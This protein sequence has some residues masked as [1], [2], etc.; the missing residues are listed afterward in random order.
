MKTALQHARDRMRITT[1]VDH[2]RILAAHCA[3]LDLPAPV[4]E[5]PFWKGRQFK[6]DLAWPARRFACEVEG[7]TYKPH[8]HELG[9]RHVS[10]KG[11]QQDLEKYAEAAAQGWIVLRV[12]PFHVKSGAAVTWIER[13]LAHEACPF[14][15]G[16]GRVHEGV[17]E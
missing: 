10:A 2:G 8:S 4:L 17:E 11:F 16:T 15:D 7:V 9:G 5:Y 14:C 12:L 3:A 1:R 6:F 13:I